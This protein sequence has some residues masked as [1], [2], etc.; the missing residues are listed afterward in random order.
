VKI[1]NISKI[2]PEHRVLDIGVYNAYVNFCP[3]CYPDYTDL[4]SI[5]DIIGFGVDNEGYVIEVSVC[6][7][8]FEKSHHHLLSE[9]TYTMFKIINKK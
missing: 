2:N 4:L 3:F 7:V 9:D 5:K 6:P 8:C 1:N